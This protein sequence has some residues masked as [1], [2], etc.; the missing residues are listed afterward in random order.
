ML[1]CCRDQYCISL[2]FYVY[3]KILIIKTFCILRL[4][5]ST[6][7]QSLLHRTVKSRVWMTNISVTDTFSGINREPSQRCYRISSVLRKFCYYL[8][9]LVLWQTST[10]FP[11][12]CTT[13]GFSTCPHPPCNYIEW[14]F[15]FSSFKM[16]HGEHY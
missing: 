10:F 9:T 1:V 12:W 3:K 6:A 11:P 15:K 16:V 13:G 7:S 8:L 5:E 4:I 14:G 2:T